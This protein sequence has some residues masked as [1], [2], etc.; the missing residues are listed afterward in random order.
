MQDTHGLARQPHGLLHIGPVN[1]QGYFRV[2]TCNLLYNGF[3]IMLPQRLDLEVPNLQSTGT[4]TYVCLLAA[5]LPQ[6][7]K[8]TSEVS[9]C[10][11]TASAQ[12]PSVGLELKASRATKGASEACCESVQITAHVNA[13]VRKQHSYSADIA[14]RLS[15]GQLEQLTPAVHIIEATRTSR[16]TVRLGRL[17]KITHAAV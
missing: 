15:R 8:L 6:T 12:L 11:Y 5:G 10:I 13:V 2:C 4:T 7:E 14:K 9:A 16:N 1:S 3:Y 17:T